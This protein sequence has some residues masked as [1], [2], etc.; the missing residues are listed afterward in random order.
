MVV[1][2]YEYPVEKGLFQLLVHKKRPKTGA[3]NVCTIGYS[4]EIVCSQNAEMNYHS[5]KH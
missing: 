2:N 4:K 3:A 1:A 5:K